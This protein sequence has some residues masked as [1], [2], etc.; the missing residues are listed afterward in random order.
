[1]VGAVRLNAYPRSAFR[2]RPGG[3]EP[4]PLAESHRVKAAVMGGPPDGRGRHPERRRGFPSTEKLPFVGLCTHPPRTRTASCCPLR[5][6]FT[7]V[8]GTQW[9]H[10]SSV[11]K[12]K[13][14]VSGAFRS[15]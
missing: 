8:L 3:S 4:S 1:M 5:S 6:G 10:T 7:Q 2:C 15:G 13:S 11:V 9:G 12:T 14:P